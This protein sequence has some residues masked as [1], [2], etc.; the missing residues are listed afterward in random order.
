MGRRGRIGHQERACG[1]LKE[2]AQGRRTGQRI[3]MFSLSFLKMTFADISPSSVRNKTEA[4]I[5]VVLPRK[6]QRGEGVA[7]T[8]RRWHGQSV[9]GPR[10]DQDSAP[11]PPVPAPFPDTCFSSAVQTPALVTQSLFLVNSSAPARNSL[12][13]GFG[14]EAVAHPRRSQTRPL[15][16]PVHVQVDPGPGVRGSARTT[17]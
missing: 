17:R 4:F 6:L 8:H 15:P 9:F 1:Y 16:L 12:R 13:L 11:P 5:S 2:S 3:M 10:G 14:K 7:F